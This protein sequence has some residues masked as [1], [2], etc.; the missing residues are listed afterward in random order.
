MLISVI[1]FGFVINYHYIVIVLRNKKRLT[2]KTD[3]QLW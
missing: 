1:K 2:I 3:I